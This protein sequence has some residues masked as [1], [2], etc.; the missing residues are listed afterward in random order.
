MLV[1]KSIDIGVWFALPV[2]VLVLIMTLGKPINVQD[3]EGTLRGVS[4]SPF[5]RYES[6]LHQDKV[7]QESISD[8]LD[9]L[10]VHTRSIRTYGANENQKP[11]ITIAAERG[12]DVTA[13]AWLSGDIL[14]DQEEIDQL[15][16]LTRERKNITRVIVGNEALLRKD[17]TIDYLMSRVEEVKA[18]VN[19]P[20]STAEPW[21]VWVEFPE[22]GEKVDY[23]AAHILPYWEGIAR[24]DSVPFA[25]ERYGDLRALFPDKHILI[26]EVGWPKDG[27]IRKSAVPSNSNVE[28]FLR[29]F[30]RW[31]EADKIDYIVI[32]A[33]DQPW[34]VSTEGGVGA[35]WGLFAADRSQ[36][37][38][39]TGPISTF[40][41]WLLLSLLSVGFA[42][43]LILWFR[44]R[45]PEISVPGKLFMSGL[46]Q[47][48]VLCLLWV[49]L[50]YSEL[51][52]STSALFAIVI[53]APA[54]ILLCLVV[55]TEGLEF[56]EILWRRKRRQLLPANEIKAAY[57]PRVSI[58]V[59][60]CNEPPDMVIETLNAL[61]RLDYPNFEVL[62][63]DNNTKD[64][65]LWRP[66]QDHCE[67]LGHRFR[68]FHFDEI[69]GFKAGALNFAL[70]VTDLNAEIIA[71]IDSDYQVS[72]NWLAD[73]VPEFAEPKTAIVQAPQDYRDGHESFFKR[74]CYWE[75][76]NFFQVGMIHRNE[77]NAIIQ[78]GTMTMIRKSVLVEVGKWGEWCICED[79]ELGLR[80]FEAG[81]EAQYTNQSYG[82]GV[83][84]DTFSAYRKQRF[85]WAYGAMQIMKAHIWELL[86]RRR[87]DLTNG[88]SYHFVAGWGG[89]F[90][91][92]LN[93]VVCSLSV[94]WTVALTLWP[95]TFDYPLS[96]FMIFTLGFFALK[97]T[98]SLI[99]YPT[100][101]G[102]GWADTLGA[103]VAGLSLSYTVG[104]A[105][106]YGLF[107]S[108][109]PFFRTP[110]LEKRAQLLTALVDCWQE[111]IISAL[112][113]G[114]GILVALTRGQFEPEAWL[115]SSILWL[116]AVPFLSSIGMSVMSARTTGRSAQVQVLV[117]PQPTAAN[118]I[119]SPQARPAY[120]QSN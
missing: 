29:E 96:A 18:A 93:L 36:D 9:L 120:A 39:F 54:M 33:F 55:M 27:R 58:H 75:Y 34:K 105:V 110:K 91:D 51:Y 115:W 113:I 79:A 48:L 87:T 103:T 20:V 56:A 108:K 19:V 41:S 92:S 102:C 21:H 95:G 42:A 15:I 61:S 118:V 10:G 82:K 14:Q 6:P 112:L 4:Y 35:Y 38:T 101:V 73:L 78:H 31:A 45:L 12:L 13:G 76:A 7:D 111:S 85:R 43:P 88:Q 49:I 68:F 117:R 47:A 84:P 80:V 104:K 106:W 2:M 40:D 1:N 74:I 26:A 22:L 90:A 52:W 114:C 119:K 17:V 30:V 8:D 77:R 81:Y 53:L 16:A 50:R 5:N 97:V 116:Q 72:S 44:W 83:M 86:G 98:K 64:P 37:V 99:I 25:K 24:K 65:A 66:V 109:L 70:K 69:S 23:I 89:W 94:A 59:A 62:L 60:A 107:T 32:E 63:I 67:A 57:A 11:V 46:W 71:V 28:I 100:R 3:W